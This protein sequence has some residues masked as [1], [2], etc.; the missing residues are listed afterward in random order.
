MFN[1]IEGE[2]E[3]ADRASSTLYNIRRSL[4]EKIIL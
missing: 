1:A 3:I 4:K 2:D